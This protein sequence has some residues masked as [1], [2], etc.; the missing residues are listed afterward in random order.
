TIAV[1]SVK[2][3]G[4]VFTVTFPRASAAAA[5]PAAE[6]PRE[7]AGSG[8]RLLVVDDN[9]NTR[10][11][12]ARMLRGHYAVDTAGTAREALDATAD[13]RYDAVLLDINLGAGVSGEDV[14]GR[15]RTLPGYAGVPLVAFTAYAL[16]GDR[17][18]FLNAGFSGYL[19]K[20]FTKPELLGVLQGARE[21]PSADPA[22]EQKE[23]APAVLHMIIPGPGARPGENVFPF[24]S[25]DGAASRP[26]PAEDPDAAP[27]S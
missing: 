24:P 3:E 27:S 5:A 21:E 8:R 19:P 4:S 17:E 16:P 6:A 14:M 26:V 11:L 10:L 2:G 9:P 12:L 22:P 7:E 15:I 25:G 23:P 1:E 20:P 18:R 13:T